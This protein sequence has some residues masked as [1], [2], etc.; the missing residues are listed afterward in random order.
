MGKMYVGVN[1]IPKNVNKIYVGVNGVAR[2]VVKGY[3]GVNGVARVFWGG[4][5]VENFWFYYKTA[6]GDVLISEIPNQGGTEVTWKKWNNSI[7]FFALLHYEG[8]TNDYVLVLSTDQ[9]G[10]TCG[11]SSAIIDT[12]TVTYNNT[13]WYWGFC[14]NTVI[15]DAY[16][17]D[18]IGCRLPDYA[19][20][21]TMRTQGIQDVLGK[22]YADDFAENYQVGNTYNLVK[23]DMEKTI[24]KFIAMYLLLNLS[25][26]TNYPTAFTSILT[27]VEDI[28]DYFLESKGNNDIIQL[29]A[30]YS[31]DGT[32]LAFFAYYSNDTLT[33]V[34]IESYTPDYDGY[35]YYEGDRDVSYN[36]LAEIQFKGDGTIGYS[37]RSTQSTDWLYIG[38]A[39]YG[40][41]YLQLSNMGLSYQTVPHSLV[42]EY[43]YQAGQT[44]TI[45][46][47]IKFT[48]LLTDTKDLFFD[49]ATNIIGLLSRSCMIY[50][51]DHWG[52]IKSAILNQISGAGLSFTSLSVTISYRPSP[53]NCQMEIKLGTSSFPQQIGIDSVSQDVEGTD[54]Y[55]F[56]SLRPPYTRYFTVTIYS[57]RH[58]LSPMVQVSQYHQHIGVYIQTAGSTYNYNYAVEG[59]NYGMKR[60]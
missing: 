43:D 40:T 60:T 7:T 27:H 14:N 2:K 18:P 11:R 36:L 37:T 42:P 39:G 47:N 10:I 23:A 48:D 58:N 30:D 25:Q 34:E 35:S 28:V 16:Y 17:L 3:V 51:R 21:Q 55:Y 4:G 59:S 26:K 49:Y 45:H 32:G 8:Y 22:I 31:S 57:D 50:F 54:Y 44:Y 33:N 24:R 13:T 6:N 41:D 52:D 53:D 56:N 20:Q 9:N 19:T 12:G 46:A 15:H 38:R 1:N 5:V 29:G